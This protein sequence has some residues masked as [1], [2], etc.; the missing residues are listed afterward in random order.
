VL[1]H[2]FALLLLATL[3]LSGCKR[4]SAALAP[5]A[6]PPPS[7]A[8]KTVDASVEVDELW[9]RAMRADPVDLAALADR[10]GAAGLMDGV[11]QGGEVGVAALHA[12]PHADDA[13]LALRRLGEIA[14]QTDGATQLDVVDVVELI[15]ARP[16]R[17]AEVLD[18]DGAR[19]CSKAL[20]EIARKSG[21]GPQ[22]RAK[23]ISA[24]RHM[25]DWLVVDPKQIPTDLDEG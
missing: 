20:L 3:G 9:R 5:D 2:A 22:T 18:A 17:Q 12:L 11:E 10:E 7:F 13:E 23:A 24:L 6:A 4:K 16:I 15:A 21:A 14:L 19:E 8:R 1:R 25:V